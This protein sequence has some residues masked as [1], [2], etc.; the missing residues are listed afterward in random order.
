MGGDGSR[1]NALTQQRMTELTVHIHQHG[2]P[3][4][5]LVEA[6]PLPFLAGFMAA[7]CVGCPVF[8]CNP[9]WGQQEWEQ[10]YALA[11]PNLIWGDPSQPA[12]SLP[13]ASEGLPAWIMIPTGGSSGRLRF[14]IHTWSTLMASV[15]GV[16]Q[17]FGGMKGARPIHSCCVLPLYHVSGL[18]QFLRSFCTGGQFVTLP[19]KQLEQGQ[20]PEIPPDT[21][22][23]SLV[24]TQ[25]QRLLQRADRISWLLRFQTI[26]LGGAPPWP[27]LLAQARQHQIRLAL[28]YGMTE[29]ASQVATLDPDAFLAGNDSSGQVLPHARITIQDPAGHPLGPNQIGQIVIQGQ[30]LGWGYYPDDRHQASWVTDD[31]GLISDHGDLHIVGRSSRK[32]ITGGENVFPETVEAA[33]Q[34]TSLVAD[35]YVMGVPHPDW[36][37]IVT[38]V[39]VPARPDVSTHQLRTALAGKLSPYQHPKQWIP[40]AEIPRNAQGKIN[41]PQ[42]QR[43]LS[44]R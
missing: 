5:C 8:L 20:L 41:S 33:L 39:Y 21:F 32:V 26:L 44:E 9:T 2:V 42:L 35:V 24:P 30:S 13:L 36:G 4:L 40:V 19:S 10:V 29:A 1:F 43:L 18:M 14:V 27:Q 17:H 22:F 15:Q 23:L 11:Q 7:C 37:E 16:Q 6:D 31:L 25:L 28:T 38:A 3:K 12:P 34:A